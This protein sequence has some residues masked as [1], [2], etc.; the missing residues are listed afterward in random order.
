M[1][2]SSIVILGNPRSGTTYLLSLL[3]SHDHVKR[4]GEPLNEEH[5]I[6]GDPFEYLDSILADVQKPI[7][8]FKCHSEQLVSRNLRLDDMVRE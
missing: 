1:T 7:A 4:L 8:A 5:R 6:H 3:A 2:S